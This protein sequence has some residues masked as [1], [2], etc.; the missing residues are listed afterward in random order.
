MKRRDFITSTAVAASALALSACHR[1]EEKTETGSAN[2]NKAN[3]IFRK[4]VIIQ[5]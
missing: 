2:I 5:P 4:R 1:A 3:D